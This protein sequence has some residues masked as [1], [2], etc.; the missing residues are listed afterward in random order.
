VAAPQP[1]APAGGAPFDA[2][3]SPLDAVDDLRATAKWTIVAFG[4][5]GAAMISGGPLVAIGTVHGSVHIVV[6]GLGLAAVLVGVAVA[7]W[8]TTKVLTPVITTP[9]TIE[10]LTDLT[11]LIDAHPEEF[12][13]AT[14]TSVSDLLLHRRAAVKLQRELAAETDANRIRVLTQNLHRAQANIT[15][16][17]PYLRWLLALAHVWQIQAALRRARGWTLGGGLLVVAGAVAFL[18]VTASHGPTYVP[19]VTPQITS[20]GHP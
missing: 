5:V 15:R 17:D 8:Q 19:V 11:A 2:L 3:P 4:A 7:I 1:P 16:T 6:A 18:A 10:K 12:F 9:T 13:G 14:A 20:T